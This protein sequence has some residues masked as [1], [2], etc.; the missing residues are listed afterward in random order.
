M[1]R[2]ATFV[3]K[4]RKLE[5]VAKKILIL[6]GLKLF[7]LSNIILLFEHLYLISAKQRNTQKHTTVLSCLRRRQRGAP[8]RLTA[9]AA[10]CG[11]VGGLGQ[12]V[13]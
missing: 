5:I 10:A 3:S 9:G 7:A 12:Q 6:Y 13:K 11:R 2:R 4:I 1:K 8:S